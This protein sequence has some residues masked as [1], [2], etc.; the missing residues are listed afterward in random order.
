[1]LTNKQSTGFT[2][3]E[4]MVTVAIVGILAT[5]ALPAYTDYVN[6]AKRGDGKAAL[7]NAQ[8]AQE[9][10]RANNITYAADI[11]DL[12]IG[13][14]SPDGYYTIAVTAANATTYTLTAT[15]DFT[16]AKCGTLG[17]NQAGTKTE[18]GSDTAAN[19]WQK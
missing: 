9:K 8:L 11:D 17:I 16:D 1:M 4:L 3:I 19:C 7:M 12:G 15:P 18:T 6:R 14:D 10:Y 13:A 2:L 5:I